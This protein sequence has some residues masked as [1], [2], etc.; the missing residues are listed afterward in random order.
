MIRA[1]PVSILSLTGRILQ[2]SGTGCLKEDNSRPGFFPLA[3]KE[4]VE[5]EIVLRYGK[6]NNLDTL[7]KPY[8]FKLTRASAGWTRAV[9]IFETRP[10]II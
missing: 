2:V 8:G 3:H 9:A 7:P 6:A 1:L 10:N 4:N 5:K